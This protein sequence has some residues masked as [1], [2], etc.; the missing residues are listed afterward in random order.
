MVYLGGMGYSN[1]DT[2]DRFERYFDELI[3]ENN[4]Q[5]PLSSHL[6]DYSTS[7]KLEK[8]AGLGKGALP[9]IVEKIKQGYFI[10]NPA[11]SEIT[12]IHITELVQ[13]QEEILSEQEIS[14][15]WIEWWEDNSRVSKIETFIA[16]WALP[17]EEVPLHININKTVP[18]SKIL[19]EVPDHCIVRE[20]INVV[21]YDKKHKK[22]EINEIGK[23]PL[24]KT[25]H[26]GVIM[27]FDKIFD[28]LAVEIPIQITLMEENGKSKTVATKA[29]IFRPLLEI[30][31]IPSDIFIVDNA[32]TVL[33]IRLTYKGFGDIALRVEGDI[34]DNI[35]TK[36]GTLL[37]TVMYGIMKEGLLTD[38]QA[39]K[40]QNE[41]NVNEHLLFD[42]IDELKTKARDPSYMSELEKNPQATKE[43]IDWL[44]NIDEAKQEGVMNVLY[45]TMETYITKKIIDSLYRNATN[46]THLD[47]GTKISTE[48]K[49]TITNIKLK[50]FYRDLVGNI[51]TPLEAAIK[52][53]DKRKNP[54]NLSVTIPIETKNVDES[55]SYENVEGMRIGAYR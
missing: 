28:E 11:I 17:N 4:E 5:P 6:G 24:A 53:V 20:L 16:P 34:E 12:K 46:K 54:K 9:F 21:S 40:S 27:A 41:I 51:Y 33:P 26:F 13:P 37:D 43:F 22:L 23:N 29:R 39:E 35:V 49:A 32:E 38:S 15:M 50:I 47:S 52:I 14:K 18:Y 45:E 44:K 42:L 3:H 10:L 48:I 31:E 19:V 25:D 55:G 8:I 36:G 7:G 1:M 2:K 30:N